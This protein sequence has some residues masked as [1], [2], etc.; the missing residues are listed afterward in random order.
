M[1]ALALA[2]SAIVKIFLGPHHRLEVEGQ[3]SWFTFLRYRDMLYTE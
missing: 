2:Q 1:N 3:G